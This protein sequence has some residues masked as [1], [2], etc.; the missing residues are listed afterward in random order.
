M[1]LRATTIVAAPIIAMAF[2][3]GPVDWTG[4][5]TQ[6][7]GWDSPGQTTAGPGEATTKEASTDWQ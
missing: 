1:P 3:A 6:T 5:D 7:T 2:A 4:P